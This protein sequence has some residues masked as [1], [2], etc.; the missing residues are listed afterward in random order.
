MKKND[1]GVYTEIAEHPLA[2]DMTLEPPHH[3]QA[4][5]SLDNIKGLYESPPA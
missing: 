1:A 3:I 5:T 4:D 2:G